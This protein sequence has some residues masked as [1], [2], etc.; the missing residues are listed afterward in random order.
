MAFTVVHD[1]NALHPASLRDFLIRL[2]GTGL[3][4]AK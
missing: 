2:A 4:R 1:A 3:Y